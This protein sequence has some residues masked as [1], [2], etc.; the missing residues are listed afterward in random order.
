MKARE[1]G[2]PEE[3]MW[4]E[5][6]EAEAIL[7]KL[8][9]SSSC[10]DVV[11]FGCGYGIHHPRR[12]HRL[13]Q[14]SCPGHRPGNRSPPQP[15]PKRQGCETSRRTFVISSHG[16]RLAAGKPEYPMLFNILHADHPDVLLEEAFRVL[17]AG[18]LL[19]VIHWNY[20]PATPRRPIAGHPTAARAVL[21]MGRR[22]RVSAS[23]PGIIDLPPYHY[24]LVFRRRHDAKSAGNKAICR[25]LK[26]L[27]VLVTRRAASWRSSKAPWRPRSGN[28]TA[29]M[30]AHLIRAPRSH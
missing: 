20:D 22:G 8:G 12:P 3:G 29:A 2:M 19:A 11:D 17:G 23:T 13:R 14:G 30:T 4:A 24:G 21:R 25:R 28:V 5:F 7:R 26:D 18:G 6:F 9:L 1:S 15:G 16:L 10:G 27:P